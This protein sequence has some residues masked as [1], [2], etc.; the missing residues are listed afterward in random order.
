MDGLFGLAPQGIELVYLDAEI[1]IVHWV[2]LLGVFLFEG[3]ALGWWRIGVVIL[4]LET[5]VRVMDVEIALLRRL[6]RVLLHVLQVVLLLVNAVAPPQDDYHVIV[7][8]T[9]RF[10]GRRKTT[11]L[12]PRN[13]PLDD[14]R[15]DRRRG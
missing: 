14:V 10:G 13:N 5:E 2:P 1:S 4:D 11:R 3:V 8:V 9:T 12:G 7:G 15:D 6:W